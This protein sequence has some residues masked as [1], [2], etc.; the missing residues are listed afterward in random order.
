MRSPRLS[1]L[2]SI[3]IAIAIAV[4]PLLEPARAVAGVAPAACASDCNGDGVVLVNELVTAVSIALGVVALSTCPGAD[5]DGDGQLSIAELID[6]VSDALFGCGV[7]PPTPAPSATPTP[8]L[9]PQPTA[10]PV[11]GLDVSG[12]WQVDQLALVA[13]T[14]PEL[15]NQVVRDEIDGGSLSCIFDVDHQ[16]AMANVVERCP[17]EAPFPFTAD[18]D[19][20]GVL[21]FSDVDDQQIDDCPFD[22]TTTISA[23]LSHSPSNG[24]ATFDFAFQPR[25]GIIRCVAVVDG[26]FTRLGDL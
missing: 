22:V 5:V 4:A 21:S 19:P 2:A 9:P 25:C 26:R 8:T 15:V 20:Q 18:V 24:S 11:P 12:R 6:A 7:S 17:G 3:A 13:S 23:D 14:C 10:T 1:L 16:G